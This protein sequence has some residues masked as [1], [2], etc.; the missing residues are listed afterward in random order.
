MSTDDA[1]QSSGTSRQPRPTA[2][3]RVAAELVRRAES[4]GVRRGELLARAGLTEADV[5]QPETRI[6][7]E[8]VYALVE[9]M[10]EL[11]GDPL[12]HMRVTRQIELASLEALAFAVLTSATLGDGLRL[13]LRFQ[14]VFSD[15]ERYE[16]S[17]EGEWARLAYHPW[18][19]R[20]R[21]HALMAE[22][23]AVDVVV[24]GGKLVGGS[25]DRPRVLFPHAAPAD[26]REHA[27]LLGGVVAEFG[28]PRCEVLL[29]TTDLNRRIAPPGQEPIRAYFEQKLEERVRALS[30]SS[31]AGVV[32]EV[33]TQGSS[34]GASVASLARRLRVSA[35]TLQRRLAEEH[36]SVRELADEARRARAI[37]LLEAG[38]PI[39]EVAENVGFTEPSAFHRAFRRW[40]GKTPEEFRRR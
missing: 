24:N 31:L 12:L 23:F 10:E 30:A 33:L 34:V 14:R 26:A 17:S 38:R 4:A 20:R 13:M 3:T 18:G 29:R 39:S 15:G 25:F 11:S 40:T 9:S 8:S 6:P 16:L 21:G 2:W 35:R 27:R 22:M 7:L 36:T 37:L 19:A 1:R 5:A 28:R 32:R